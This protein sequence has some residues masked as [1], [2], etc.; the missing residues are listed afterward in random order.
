[1]QC[2]TCRAVDGHAPGCPIAYPVPSQ[3]SRWSLTET[4]A[5]PGF[6]PLPGQ[7][8]TPNE[9]WSGSRPAVKN[10]PDLERVLAIPRRQLELDGTPRAQALIEMMTA[11]YSKNVPR[12]QCRCAEIDPKRH[13][14][15]G[16]ID[17]MRLTQALA[18]WEIGI[19]GGLLGPIGTGHG[20]TMLD[21]LAVLALAQFAG[22]ND[23]L[24]VL[25]LPPRLVKQL[26][27]DYDYVGQH[28]VMPNLVVEGG[29]GSR[30]APGMPNLRV[31]P[32]S[33]ICRENYAA[34]LSNLPGL[35]AIIA[36]EV[37]KLRDRKTGTTKRVRRVMEARPDTRFCGWS[38]S[39]TSKSIKDYAHLAAWAL[40]GASPM[41][42]VDDTTDEWARAIDP[43]KNPADPGALFDGLLATGCLKPGEPLYTGIRRRLMETRGVVST[44][45]QAV[46]VELE[47][48]ERKAPPMPRRI[49]MLISEVI[50]EW[51]RPDG[52]EF[53]TAM[54]AVACAIHLAH[55]FHYRWIYPECEFP[56]DQQL[57]D[58]YNEA[59]R[60][61]NK[62]CRNKLKIDEE[63]LDTP[64]LL[65][66][67]AE[68][69]YGFRPQ[70]RHLPVWESLT[71]LEWR[72]MR[73]LVKPKG[74]AVR[75]DDWI[76]RDTLDWASN[77]K[78]VI[79]YAH[80]AFGRWCEQLGKLPRYGAGQAA[81]E[82]LLD[83]RGDRS[84]V[85]SM[86]A[87]GTGTNGMQFAFSDAIFG[88]GF[89]PDPSACEQTL[90][91]IHRPGQKA[92]VCRAWFRMHTPELR[93]H[94]REALKNTSYVQG[95]MGAIQK[96]R[97]GFDAGLAA[98]LEDEENQE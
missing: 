16:C 19:A 64:L 86:K 92:K 26:L 45:S 52:Y 75:I 36:D 73:P 50:E 20:K 66:H 67:A 71:Y 29:H 42:L 96:L 40:K 25:L 62:E 97:A 85:V 74:D 65:E 14:K 98:E 12:G 21:L 24:A 82:A 32:Y 35:Y 51:R 48:L 77:N 70:N 22:R 79:W 93:R 27:R 11:R 49:S 53:M 44:T 7:A 59:R 56:R 33:L 2:F 63:H 1:M 57:V 80:S 58:D 5:A 76:V 89:P 13:A 72:H 68:R 43:S 18:L 8:R 17:T 69:A 87:H 38:G 55:G 91:R 4:V 37:H 10:S 81:A 83:E 28:F 61:W 31:L 95:T 3:Q 30:A 60:E 41:P 23:I 46:D 34:W 94:V 39:I 54:E 78:G 15:E 88:S 9:A 6:A 84:V 47:I 90:A